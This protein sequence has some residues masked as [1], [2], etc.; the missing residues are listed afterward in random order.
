MHQKCFYKMKYHKYMQLVYIYGYDD[1][2]QICMYRFTFVVAV[3]Y[4]YPAVKYLLW[5]TG[6]A[7]RHEDKLPSMV[8]HTIG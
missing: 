2:L 1:I 6:L 3:N 8:K 7:A 4:L 5:L